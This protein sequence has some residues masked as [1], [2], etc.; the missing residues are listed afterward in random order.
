MFQIGHSCSLGM[1]LI[2]IFN[3]IFFVVLCDAFDAVNMYKSSI[4]MQWTIMLAI[5]NISKMFI[6]IVKFIIQRS[7][8][9]GKAETFTIR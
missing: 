6:E 7:L 2:K 4:V 8:H 5:E 9:F 1:F 3:G